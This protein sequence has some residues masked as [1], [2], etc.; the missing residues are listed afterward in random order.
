MISVKSSCQNNYQGNGIIRALDF[1]FDGTWKDWAEDT[2]DKYGVGD[3]IMDLEANPTT[4]KTLWPQLLHHRDETVRFT[5]EDMV[6]S[7]A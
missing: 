3:Y 2:L 1:N 5:A 7:S 4:P 6:K